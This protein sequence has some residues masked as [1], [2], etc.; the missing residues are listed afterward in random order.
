MNPLGDHGWFRAGSKFVQR[1]GRP[2]KFRQHLDVPAS[3]QVRRQINERDAE[4]M[5]RE[6]IDKHVSRRSAKKER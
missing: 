1:H 5:R 3:V 4:R 2:G 6:K